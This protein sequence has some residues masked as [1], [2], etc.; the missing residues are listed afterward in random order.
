MYSVLEGFA[1]S[2]SS[3]VERVKF[4]FKGDWA[5][6][7]LVGLLGDF[8]LDD[9]AAARA[10]GLPRQNLGGNDYHFEVGKP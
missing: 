3:N 2:F 4:K 7:R 9:S 8:N 6:G 5:K 1:K 10:V